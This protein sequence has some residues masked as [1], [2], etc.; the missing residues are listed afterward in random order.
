MTQP[1]L[2]LSMSR[3]LLRFAARS[4]IDRDRTARR[5]SGHDLLELT[6]LFGSG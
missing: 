4:R 3:S 1:R 2:E 5:S 6:L